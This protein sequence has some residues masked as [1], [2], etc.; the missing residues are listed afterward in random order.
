MTLDVYRSCSRHEKRQ[1]LDAFW[2]TNVESS[3]RIRDAA[4]EYGPY[5]VAC[6]V[7]VAAELV[8]LIVVS[9]HRAPVI[10]WIAVVV[11]AVVALSLWWAVVRSRAL[12]REIV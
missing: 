1:V 5:A 11:E 7:A 10:S 2:H 3:R 4:V 6:L 12:R 9:I 8:V